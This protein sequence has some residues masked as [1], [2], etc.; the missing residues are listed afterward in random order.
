MP[1]HPPEV[2]AA[3]LASLGEAFVLAWS[4]MPA[5]LPERIS[6]SQLRALVAVRRAGELTVT[7]LA[8]ALDALPSSA[9]RLCDRLVAAGL[10]ERVPS[11]VNR[12]F[13]AISLTSSGQRLLEAL[14]RHRERALAAVL[15]RM[16]PRARQHLWEG[17][18]A[19]ADQ[20]ERPEASV[21][22]AWALPSQ[23]EH[24]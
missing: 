17:L 14:D 8:R 6:A 2:L 12:R 3:E 23:A 4:G 9:T 18:S 20:A 22:S 16:G 15:A 24:G 7:E 19:F 13:H 10:I 1:D 5:D 11:A 21:R